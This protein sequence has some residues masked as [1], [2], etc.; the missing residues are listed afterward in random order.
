MSIDIPRT[1]SFDPH[2]S[3]VK[4]NSSDINIRAWNVIWIKVTND[5]IISIKEP[6]IILSEKI[7]IRRIM[8]VHTIFK[9]GYSNENR[10]AKSKWRTPSPPSRRKKATNKSPFLPMHAPVEQGRYI[11][12]GLKDLTTFSQKV[13][14]SI[15]V[16]RTSAWLI[17]RWPTL[18]KVTAAPETAKPT[19]DPC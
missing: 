16:E 10:I 19:I 9:S 3:I 5:S 13:P 1:C 7:Q 18:E 6:N 14:R 12:L 2:Y 17:A 11:F 15:E 4:L 8:T